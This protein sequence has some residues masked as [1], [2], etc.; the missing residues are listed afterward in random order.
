VIHRTRQLKGIKN[1]LSRYPVVAI[2][3][4]RQVGK[5]TLARQVARAWKTSRW[6]DLENDE[7]LSKLSEPMAA[8]KRLQG[9]VVLDEV[10]RRPEIFPTLRVLA[11]QRGGRRFLILGSA[12]PS[13]LRQSSE[14]L[15]GRITY[16]TLDGFSPEETGLGKT[17][18]LWL[19]GGYPLS[20]L[21]RSDA[22]SLKWRKDLIK[23]FLERDIPQLQVSI[24]SETLRRF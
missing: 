4:P 11:D 6:F 15:A 24:P 19:R 18:R 13:L 10:Q 8:L 12:S 16:H 20:F 5:T 21:S 2:L 22:T 9:L 1:L 3:G 23:T 7:D 17:D 14:S